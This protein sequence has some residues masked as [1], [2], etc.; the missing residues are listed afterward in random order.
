MD[1]IE[2]MTVLRNRRILSVFAAVS[3]PRSTV[4]SM[5][6]HSFPHFSVRDPPPWI[7][8]STHIHTFS[9]SLPSHCAD[10]VGRVSSLTA[11]DHFLYAAVKGCILCLNCETMEPARVF[12]AYWSKVRS[13]IVINYSET[14][15]R[16]FQRFLSH[17]GDTLASS[18]S[19]GSP[20]QRSEGFRTFGSSSSVSSLRST[21]R[22][23]SSLDAA[24][25]DEMRHSV[26]ISFG[27]G[28]KGVVG[29]HSEHP[30]SFILPSDGSRN[31]YQPAKPDRSTGCLLLWS[32]EEASKSRKD[33]DQ[34]LSAGI[35]EVGI[36]EADET[37]EL[38]M[39]DD[40]ATAY[41]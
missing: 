10:G 2:A 19:L 41:P 4:I 33:P 28:Y 38:S 3:Y 13:L 16:H 8:H 29:D 12:D 20:N 14:H 40:V 15:S 22:S 34:C 31:N 35:P 39:P 6:K 37:E 11:K 36:P 32:T 5:V 24:A 1:A 27:V 26:L 9:H 18:Y 17:S 23:Q 25:G 21:P 30:E 7:H